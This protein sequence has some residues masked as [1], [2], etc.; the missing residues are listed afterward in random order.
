MATTPNCARIEALL[1]VHDEQLSFLELRTPI[2]PAD[3]THPTHE[4]PGSAIGL[5]RLLEELG[6][7]GMGTVFL[8][9]QIEPVRRQVALKIL[10]ASMDPAIIA[11]FEI[12]RQALA[13]MDHPNIAKILDAGMVGTACRTGPDPP[14]SH[15][16]DPARQLDDVLDPLTA[17]RRTPGSAAACGRRAASGPGL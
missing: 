7:C 12:D 10:K 1:H 3:A 2:L 14:S 5:Y 4:G 13:L 9:D 11:R 6:E 16:N 8:A 15:A 17:R